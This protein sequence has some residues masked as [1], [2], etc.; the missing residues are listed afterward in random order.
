LLSLSEK[1]VVPRKRGSIITRLARQDSAEWSDLLQA[2]KALVIAQLLVWTRPV[3]RFVEDVRRFSPGVQ[4]PI[5]RSSITWRDALRTALAVRRAADN[6]LIRPKCLVRA[7]ALSRMLDQRGIAGSRVRIGV[8]R[9]DGVFSAHAWVELG[10]HVL[11][12]DVRNVSSFAQLLDVSVV[13]KQEMKRALT[14]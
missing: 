10:Q 3:G 5:S 7:V 1:T 4:E 8:R 12:D 11:G 2:Q 6:G 13:K 9:T 14:A